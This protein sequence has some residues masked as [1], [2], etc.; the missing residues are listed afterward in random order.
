MRHRHLLGLALL[1]SEVVACGS[2][3]DGSSGR[4]DGAASGGASTGGA[5]SATG[6]T[7]SAGGVT[8]SGGT[9]SGAGGAGSGGMAATGGAPGTGGTV[10]G[11]VTLRVDNVSGH[12]TITIGGTVA[13]NDPTH[14]GCIQPGVVSLKAHANPGF[15]LASQA[16]SPATTWHG[17]DDD[18]GT[19][20]TTIA[21]T[22]NSTTITVGSSSVCVWACCPLPDGSGCTGIAPAP[23]Q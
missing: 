8:G 13:F 2:S 18:I 15:V 22:S 5:T 7:T 12:C 11:C 23:C 21:G 9:S 20:T 4:P 1:I 14:S 16:T 19:T 17:T 3:T 10:S 6:G